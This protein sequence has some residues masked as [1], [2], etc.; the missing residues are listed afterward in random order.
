MCSRVKALRLLIKTIIVS[1]PFSPF[2]YT[3]FPFS[4]VFVLQSFHFLLQHILSTPKSS[5]FLLVAKFSSPNV[6]IFLFTDVYLFVIVREGSFCPGALRPLCSPILSEHGIPV[7][8]G[9]HN[10]RIALNEIKATDTFA[11]WKPRHEGFRV[12]HS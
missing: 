8:N 1:F 7:T 3:L 5:H 10:M 4:F 2:S 11:A 6:C 9:R 12:D